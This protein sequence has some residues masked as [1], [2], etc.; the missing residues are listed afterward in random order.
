MR[1]P[2]AMA[3]MMSCVERID[4]CAPSAMPSRMLCTHSALA[5]STAVAKDS[6]RPPLQVGQGGWGVAG[7]GE[8]QLSM[9]MVSS[10][11]DGGP[12]QRAPLAAE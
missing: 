5:S 11:W 8:Y 10:R 4:F 9:R 7:T 2:P 3:S 12:P 1:H 6:V